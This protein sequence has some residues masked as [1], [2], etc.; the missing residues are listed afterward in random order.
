MTSDALLTAVR[1]TLQA[2]VAD[3]GGR[4]E[5]ARSMEEAQAL[6]AG[7]PQAWRL[8]LAWPGYGSHPAAREGVTH[9]QL[10]TVIQQRR[11]LPAGRD[12]AVLTFAAR[13]EQVS[14][15]IR[16]LRFP[17]GWQVDPA[18]F[19]LSSST[20]L[21]APRT[22]RVHAITWQLEA[23]LPPFDSTITVPLPI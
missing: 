7:A 17:D 19:S 6:L 10:T 15:W 18:G 2:R 12:Q 14:A 11:G 9:H 4:I 22:T 5:V 23:A 8:I 16:A 3:A 1:D 20:W 13:I 21:E